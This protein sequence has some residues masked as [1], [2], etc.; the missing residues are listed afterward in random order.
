MY[1]KV[2]PALIADWRMHWREGNFA[3]LFVQI[4][5]FKSDATA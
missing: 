5:S 2:F 3:F 4:S 1:E